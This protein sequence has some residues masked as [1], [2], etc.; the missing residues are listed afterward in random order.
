MNDVC[1]ACGSEEIISEMAAMNCGKC[2]AALD[3]NKKGC[4]ECHY[5]WKPEEECD[6]DG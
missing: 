2:F 6:C 1:P 4:Q 3:N 5:T